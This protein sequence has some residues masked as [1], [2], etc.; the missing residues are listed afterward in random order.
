VKRYAQDLSQRATDALRTA[1]VD[2]GVSPDAAASRAY[3]AAFYAVSALFAT[4]GKDFS[5]HSAVRAAVHR[6][7]V[8]VGIW[9]PALGQDYSFLMEQREIG[10]YGGSKRVTRE[11]AEECLHAARR[12][13][14]A[15]R[16]TCPELDATRSPDEAP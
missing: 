4:K 12:I 10:D 3:Y 9:D 7:L 16:G 2:I 11:E 8:N 1:E 15:V 6:D 13:V 5:K 14:E